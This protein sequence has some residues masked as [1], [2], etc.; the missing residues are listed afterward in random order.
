[1]TR[2][3]RRGSRLAGGRVVAAVLSYVLLYVLLVSVSLTQIAPVRRPGR[4][5][6][7]GQ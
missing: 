4:M 1:M 6:V 3:G 5:R 2:A 7:T